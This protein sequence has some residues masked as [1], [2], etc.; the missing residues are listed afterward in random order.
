MHP[1][2]SLHVLEK[3]PFT[4]RRLA[5]GALNGSLENLY[6]ICHRIDLKSIPSDQ[7][8]LFLPVFYETLDPSRIPNIDD[9]DLSSMPDSMV[10]AVKSLCKLGDHDIPYDIFP[11]LWP[12][13][14]KWTQVFHAYIAS[15]PPSPRRPEPKTFYFTFMGFIASFE[16][17]GCGAVVSATPGA[18]KLIAETW[19]F[20]LNVDESSSLRR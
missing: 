17:K 8:L 14:W 18:R 10:L 9:L 6:K 19:S 11:D 15:L 2:L 3:L 7:A 16:N 12:R 4:L 1:A 5:T 20:I 13:Y